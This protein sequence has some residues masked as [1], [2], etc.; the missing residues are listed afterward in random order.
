MKIAKP[1]ASR[2]HG[3]AWREAV[4]AHGP[5]ATSRLGY[6]DVTALPDR[7]SVMSPGW[8]ATTESMSK[9]HTSP[10][11]PF[12]Q[13]LQIGVLI[14]TSL[15]AGRDMLAGI[16]E[17]VRRHDQWII[18][19]YAHDID[20]PPPP[21]F[22]QW[23][24]D[25]IIVRLNNARIAKALE[26]REV[27]IVDVQGVYDRDRYP[28]VHTDNVAIGQLAAEHFQQRGF[29]SFGYFGL[30]DENWSVERHESFAAC[31]KE[32]GFECGCLTWTNRYENR[33]SMPE[34]MALIGNWLRTLQLPTAVFVCNDTRALILRDAALSAGF[35]VGRDIAI[36]GVGN[37]E[38]F[39][40][41]PTPALSSIDAD[42]R[43]VGYEAAHLL[44]RMMK[45]K[46][47]PSQPV[48]IPPRDVVV[49]ESTDFLAVQD[50]ALRN[51][52]GYIRENATEGITVDDVA[53]A[54]FMSRSVLQRRF[55]DHLNQTVHGFILQE[56]TRRAIRLIRDT[57]ESIE[58]IAHRTGFE[59]VQSLNKALRR[60]YGRSAGEYRQ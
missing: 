7:V 59:Y 38:A 18:F 23:R 60:L 29:A 37:D 24:C 16:A 11:C 58:N 43:K 39:C 48:L 30:K 44:D 53:E 22:Q 2:L 49:R 26:D 35:A 19:K 3:G 28:L 55:R 6:D 10:S 41:T 8:G 56:K 46:P 32:M 54:C 15:A 20:K 40:E 9:S 25:G 5:V 34:Q 57:N 50:D 4:S 14:E 1:M 21:W 33:S 13:Y 12:N 47:A 42:H 27:P 45:G 36:L 51:A 17:Y 52:L 31:V